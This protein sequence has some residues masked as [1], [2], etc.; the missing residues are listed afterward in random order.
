M[1]K[2]PQAIEVTSL[3][4]RAPRYLIRGQPRWHSLVE[5]WT[6]IVVGLLVTLAANALLFPLFGWE[7]S[8]RQNLALGGLYTVIS[9]ARSYLLRR[10]FNRWHV[11]SALRAAGKEEHGEK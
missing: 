2:E 9:L 8:T 6:N 7:I 5:A 3:E 1:D 11:K 10:A 4:D